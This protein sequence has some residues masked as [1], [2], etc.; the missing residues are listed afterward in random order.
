MSP[1]AV[2]IVCPILHVCADEHLPGRDLR[3]RWHPTSCGSFEM[4]FLAVAAGPPSSESRL[5]PTDGLNANADAVS[6]SVIRS[7][8]LR[9]AAGSLAENSRS[10][11]F[12]PR[13]GRSRSP[14]SRGSQSLRAAR[15]GDGF[16]PN[17]V[18]ERRLRMGRLFRRQ[19]GVP[20]RERLLQRREPRGVHRGNGLVA[21]QLL[22]E[23][24]LQQLQLRVGLVEPPI[25]LTKLVES[26]FVRVALYEQRPF[27]RRRILHVEVP[28][29]RL[30]LIDVV[31]G[32]FRTNGGASWRSGAKSPF[33]S[34]LRVRWTE[35][36]FE[37]L[38]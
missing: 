20:L 16:V 11:P 8:R 10:R 4:I 24:R 7:A 21:S 3:A 35:V 32:V 5:P 22:F 12:R 30:R 2:L 6:C 28:K 33:G 36:T 27:L 25:V 9:W 19:R 38:D 13:C 1:S 29:D 14:C 34:L 31:E 37:E 17:L 26:F 15:R 18:S 23:L